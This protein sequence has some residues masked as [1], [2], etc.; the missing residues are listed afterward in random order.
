MVKCISG[1]KSTPHNLYS[2]MTVAIKITFLK[3]DSIVSEKM[4]ESS[5]I[6]NLLIKTG[7]LE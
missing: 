6:D 3:G 4:H 2:H 5:F 1:I 7:M